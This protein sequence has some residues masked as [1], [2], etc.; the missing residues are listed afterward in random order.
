M[1]LVDQIKEIV[2]DPAL[3]GV[4]EQ[5]ASM[6]ALYQEMER[7]GFTEKQGYTIASMDALTSSSSRQPF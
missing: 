6:Q 5:V 2:T 7:L 3:E 4:R 1:S